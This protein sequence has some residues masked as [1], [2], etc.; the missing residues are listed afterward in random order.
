VAVRVIVGEAEIG[1]GTGNVI[2]G[3]AVGSAGDRV[4][5]KTSV[6]SGEARTRPAVTVKAGGSITG[7][8]WHEASRNRATNPNR[9]I[10]RGIY[11]HSTSQGIMNLLALIEN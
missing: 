1:E 7:R 2:V 3:D 5:V 4:G 11:L 9:K 8:A 10:N 6:A